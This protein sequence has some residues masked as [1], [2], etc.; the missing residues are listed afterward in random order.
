MAEVTIS[1][2]CDVAFDIFSREMDPA[3]AADLIDE[4]EATPLVQSEQLST[5][6]PYG[7]R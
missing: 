6:C 3:H 5:L 7:G 1:Q 2:A 4:M